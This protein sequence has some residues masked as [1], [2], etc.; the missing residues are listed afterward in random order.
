MPVPLPRIHVVH[1]E[2]PTNGN[3]APTRPLPPTPYEEEPEEYAT[4]PPPG[5]VVG[6]VEK[7]MDIVA[8]FFGGVSRLR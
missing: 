8:S 6:S 4:L 2:P 3:A 7:A 5:P 1:K